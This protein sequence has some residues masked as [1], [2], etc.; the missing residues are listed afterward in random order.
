MFHRI[1]LSQIYVYM[2]VTLTN[3]QNKNVIYTCL[4]RYE[5]DKNIKVGI[6]NALVFGNIDI[7]PYKH[8][9]KIID[10][11]GMEKSI[12]VFEKMECCEHVCSLNN[13]QLLTVFVNLKHAINLLIQL[14]NGEI[15]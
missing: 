3:Q 15:V 13:N 6:E 9:N 5:N 7:E 1:F 11:Y 2:I 4:Q 12:P 10:D 8:Y 14:F